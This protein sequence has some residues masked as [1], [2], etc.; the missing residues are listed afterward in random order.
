MIGDSGFNAATLEC[1]VSGSGLRYGRR[2]D[3]KSA[4]KVSGKEGWRIIAMPRGK[5]AA[6][7]WMCLRRRLISAG[8]EY[9]KSVF[10]VVNLL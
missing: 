4:L 1:G 2:S 6:L 10:I 9:A 7:H 3:E 5:V 8:T